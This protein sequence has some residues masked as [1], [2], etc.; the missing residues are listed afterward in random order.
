MNLSSF[1]SLQPLWRVQLWAATHLL[2]Q[3]GSGDLRCD[4]AALAMRGL[5]SLE[6]FAER[7]LSS[8]AQRNMRRARQGANFAAAITAAA[9][10]VAAADR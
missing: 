9:T 3:D 7:Q 4:I 6:T 1:A 5:S 2:L 8:L 10:V